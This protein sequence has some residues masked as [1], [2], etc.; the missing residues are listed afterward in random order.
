MFSQLMDFNL[1]RNII[2]KCFKEGLFREL[3]D[4]SENPERFIRAYIVPSTG[5]TLITNE[6]PTLV[7][8][9]QYPIYFVDIPKNFRHIP[10]QDLF[11]FSRIGYIY[12]TETFV[13]SQGGKEIMGYLQDE[14]YNGQ[15]SFIVG[16]VCGLIMQAEYNDN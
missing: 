7:S 12:D 8:D 15:S 3:T 1:N 11:I 4:V 6:R 16:L 10:L 5:G 2:R 13:G 14:K 9:Y